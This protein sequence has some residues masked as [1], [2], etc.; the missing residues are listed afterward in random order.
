MESRDFAPPHHL[1]TERSALVHGAASRMSSGGHSSVQHPAHF[2][3]GKYY[4]A[5]LAMAPHSGASFMGSFLANSL[6]SP[7]S[8]PSHPSGPATAPSSPSYRT[9]PNASPIWFPHSH[10]G[11][12]NYSGSLASP[13][14]PMSP[15]DHHSNSLYGQH[16]FYESQKD[17]FYLRGLPPKPPLLSTSHSLPPLARTT[18][19]HQPSSCNRDSDNG[20]GKNI[21]DMG[22]KVALSLSKEKERSSSKERHQDTKEKQH[23]IHH[24]SNQSSP[25]STTMGFHHQG[26]PHPHTALLPHLSHQS[27][28][29][30][31]RHLSERHNEYR[32]VDANS[33]GTKHMSACKLSGG[34]GGDSGTASKGVTGN[35]YS[36]GVGNRPPTAGRRHYKDGSMSGELRVSDNPVSS[37]ECMKRGATTN[38]LASTTHS[39]GS[40]SMPPPLAPPP[41]PL[42]MGPTVT[43]GWLHHTH[44]EFYCPPPPPALASSKDS[45]PTSGAR[46]ICREASVTG[47][48][49]VPSVGPLGDLASPEGRGGGGSGRK[50]DDK[51]GSVSYENTTNHLSRLSSCHKRE[52]PQPHQQHMGYGKADKPPDWNQQ[53]QH[54]QKPNSSLSTQSELRSCSVETP[55][56]HRDV[57]IVDNFY[58]NPVTTDSKVQGAGQGISKTGLDTSSPPYRDCSH[59]G[60]LPNGMMVSVAAV[61]REGQKVARIRHQQHGS[62][63]ANSDE[64]V[65]DG[66]KSAASWGS[67]A[68]NQDELRKGLHH[69]SMVSNQSPN[70]DHNQA[71]SQPP[72]SSLHKTDSELSAMKN[73]MN[74]S[75]QQP[76]LL[77]QRSPFGGLGSLKQGGERS[78]KADRGG[79]KNNSSS[80]DLPKQSLPLRRGSTNE[81]DKGDKC[82]KEAGEAGEGEVRQPP[83]G[84]AVAVARPPHR[85]PDDTPGHSRQGRV[86]PSMKGVSRPV[87]PLSREADER[88]RMTEEQL[89]LHHLDRDREMIIRENKDRM[90]FSRIHPSSSCHSDLASHLLVPGGASQLGADPAHHHWMRRTGSPSL[91]MGHSYGLSHVG[92][93]ASFP[94]GLPSPLQPVLGSL[95]QDPNSPLVVLSDTGPHHHLDV[96]EQ[97]GLWPPMYGSRGPPPHLQH[98]PVYSR[99]AFLRQ[100]ELYA[101]QQQRAMEHLQCHSLAQRK[102]EEHSATIEDPPSSS[103]T[104]L[105][106]SSSTGTTSSHVAKPFSHTPPPAPKTSTPSPVVYPST[107]H[108]PCYHSPSRRSHPPNPLT[109][110]PSPAAVA[111]RSPALSPAPSHL[112]KGL[113]RGS[114]RGEGQPPQD[115]PQS[116]EPDLPPVYNYPSLTMDYKAGPSPPEARLAETSIEEADPAEP[117]SKSL[118]LP[119]HIQPLSKE[120]RKCGAVRDCEVVESQS[121]LVEGKEEIQSEFKGCSAS[122]PESS[123]SGL[124]PCPSSSSSSSSPSDLA[125]FSAAK[126][127]AIRANLSQCCL[128]EEVTLNEMDLSK[129]KE[130]GE[131]QGKENIAQDAED[132]VETTEICDEEK[133]GDEERVENAEVLVPAEDLERSGISQDENSEE[134][135]CS[136][137]ESA[138]PLTACTSSHHQGAYMWSLELLIAAALW[139]TRD[140]LYPPVPVI[141]HAGHQSHHGMEMLGELAELEI[142]HRSQ[143]SDQKEANG[144]HM[145][146][147]D[148]QSLATLAA[149]RALEMGAGERIVA[150]NKQCPIRERLNLRRKCNWT[151]RHEPVCPVKGSMETIGGEEL[152]MRVQ[153]AEL[154]RRYKEKQ[155]ELAKLQRK[156]DHQKEETCRSP[157]RRGP[158]RPRKRKSIPGPSALD[159]S[160]KPRHDLLEEKNRKK[161]STHAF[162][163]SQMK[164]RCK[165]RGRPSSLSSRLARRVT[166]LK[167]KAVAQRASPAGGVLQCRGSPDARETS[168]NHGRDEGQQLDWTEGQTVKRKRGRKPKVDPNRTNVTNIQASEN[169][170]VKGDRSESS[171]HEQED[172]EEEDCSDEIVN[173][174]SDNKTSSSSSDALSHPAGTMTLSTQPCRPQNNRGRCKQHGTAASVS[175]STGTSSPSSGPKRLA[176]KC[177]EHPVIKRAALP[178]WAPSSTGY[179]FSEIRGSTGA[180][181]KWISREAS[182]KS[183]AGRCPLGKDKG[184]AVSR[185][186]QSFAADEDFHMDEES[187]F[188]E[189][190][191]EEEEEENKLTHLPPNMPSKIPA[192]PNCVLSKE[193]L[194]DGLKI[195]IS[196]EDELLY[197]A[198]V[199]TLE[200]PDI[201]SVVIEGE[202]GNR[203]RIYS[204]E[205][206]LR[207]AVLDVRPQTE[208]ILTA[209]TRVCAYWSERSRCLYPGYVHRGGPGEEKEGSVM[210]EFDDGDRGRISLSNI[211]LLPPGYQICCAEPSPALLMSPSRGCR[212][213]STQEKKDTPTENS[214]NDDSAG[215]PQEKRPVGRPKKIQ[216]ASTSASAQPS[217]AEAANNGKASLL[218]WSAPRKC[219][220]DDFFLFNG[221]SRKTQKRTREREAGM[222]HRPTSQSLAPPTPLKG[223]FGSPFAVDSFSSIANGHSTFGSG[224]SSGSVRPVSSISPMGA[225]EGGHTTTPLMLPAGNRKLLSER[226]RKHLMVK[227]D[228]E[229]VTS[230]KTKNGKALLRLG[231]VMRVG[232]TLNSSGAPLRYIHPNMLVKS[233]KHAAGHR[234]TSGAQLKAKAPLQKKPLLAGLAAKGD[235][236]TAYQSDCPSSYSELDEDDEEAVQGERTRR[237]SDSPHTGGRYLSRLSVCFSSSSSSSSSSG[238]LSSS[239]ICSSDSS[240]SSDEESS[241][242]MLRR[243]LLQ[244]DKHRKTMSSDLHGTTSNSSLSTA[245]P[246]HTYMAKSN[247]TPSGSKGR[248]HR[249]DDRTDY[250]G[251]GSVSANSS[252]AKVQMKR[253][254]GANTSHHQGQS[255][256][257]SQQPKTS[258]KDTVAKRQRMSSPEPLSNTS[259]L[260]PGRQLWRWSGNPTQ[261][262]G[263]KGKARKLFYKAIV[264]G[265]ETVRVGDCAVFLSP[266]R[267]QLPYVGRVESLWE[268]W[269]SSMVVRVKWFY[270]PE[271]TRLG[272]RHRDGKNALYQSSHED[273]NDVQTISHRCQ[274]VSRAEYDQLIQ[275]RK[276]GN[277]A[278]DLFYLAGT[279]E[280]TTGQLISADGVAIVS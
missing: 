76:L 172:E 126:G 123:S 9:G 82:R 86:L 46:D 201:F 184:H 108:S 77:P 81:G 109:P 223:I 158:G 60:N 12:P 249:P 38:I 198:C 65:K 97:S 122:E 266:G 102:Q 165:H 193:M 276:T 264:R 191:E 140:A 103:R 45:A 41:H 155:R 40:Y 262:R 163:A 213:N 18:P 107:R 190:E 177:S 196:K 116:L 160:K 30:E 31:H 235:Y 222:F 93:G 206:L 187:S 74:Y 254:E 29:E 265:K 202:R 268:S 203:P 143:Q 73:L 5:H 133:S 214:A 128:H 98:L 218:S 258:N 99:S 35:G 37:S 237:R 170:D 69:A 33:Q 277:T 178:Y 68:A 168:K 154:Q 271:E 19:N 121:G 209:G 75:S 58:R 182:R 180:E 10:E 25:T 217:R 221:T 146:T 240:Y 176:T 259:P 173:G 147:F 129:E 32:E 270:H 49:Y 15:L 17:H 83:V 261:R 78:E 1:L 211:R 152:A 105:L 150:A 125:C 269:S 199:Q 210:V 246:A 225:R 189:G 267:P 159:D 167:Q 27:R 251:K 136:S 186:L 91:W 166:Q 59:T 88:K 138:L 229:G 215:R 64:R 11:Y 149:A 117:E 233:S 137:S 66:D 280:P 90:D 132:K 232:R 272:K 200:L 47:P 250:K 13:F 85:S 179:S 51:N 110:A 57:E 220:P 183:Q 263:L 216:S 106:S 94:P 257:T 274:V 111:P 14:L 34:F 239:S 115:Y 145:L 53:I 52:K 113:E 89:S 162:N 148:L 247:M 241:S 273:E 212:R 208:A 141:Q 56:S 245:A 279:Y 278:N 219:P 22:E 139:A 236:S 61:Q 54:F 80:Q 230:P 130:V 101:L 174:S 104:P 36:G 44:P 42:H 127:K 171:E 124:L 39:V 55:S 118:T 260:L 72:H 161:L 204:L 238:S 226:D 135:S 231:S 62:L 144:E 252:S 24:H 181:T 275:E 8:H 192:L 205:Q 26:F 71:Q 3:P 207:E 119:C 248:A 242:V 224:G 169:Q 151:P 100:Q 87:Y 7:P 131:E 96:L 175:Q 134:L 21:K 6:G 234:H 92:M 157:A 112:A 95:T 20:A 43:G 194:V 153:L 70:S 255:V 195:L 253:K 243:A 228:H 188:S 48:T 164:A 185:L 16:R 2:Q 63:G 156:H 114:D 79:G 50:V 28:E 120:E 23:Q 244:Q 84:I 256:S 142:Q 227:L 4:S 67:Q 197:A